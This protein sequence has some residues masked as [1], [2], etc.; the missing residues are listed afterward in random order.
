MAGRTHGDFHQL[1]HFTAK[2]IYLFIYYKK[3]ELKGL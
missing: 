1:S 3:A 2:N